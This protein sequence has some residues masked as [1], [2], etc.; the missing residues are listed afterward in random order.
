MT[1]LTIFRLVLVAIF[2]AL[3]AYTVLRRRA[4]AKTRAKADR[5]ATLQREIDRLSRELADQKARA[6]RA[7]DVVAASNIIPI[8][9]HDWFAKQRAS[10]ANQNIQNQLGAS[11]TDWGQLQPS[12]PPDLGPYPTQAFSGLTAHSTLIPEPTDW[13]LRKSWYKPSMFSR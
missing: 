10:S 5:E 13:N 12:R 4:A 9:E 1:A 8:A 6:K 3:C 7:E 2:L 11:M